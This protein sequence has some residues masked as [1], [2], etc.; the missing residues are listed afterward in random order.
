MATKTRTARKPREYVVDEKG[1]RTAVLVPVAEYEALLEAAEDL[2]DLRA[3]DEARV[4]GGE[5]VPWEQ[6]KAELRAKGILR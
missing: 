4:E 5:A 3:A 2:A 6:V 1:Q